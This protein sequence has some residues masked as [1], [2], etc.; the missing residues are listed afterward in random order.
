M[1]NNFFS[2][3]LALLNLP[4][5]YIVIIVVPFGATKIFFGISAAQ[6]V[7]TRERKYLAGQVHKYKT[8]VFIKSRIY[9]CEM[10]SL[11]LNTSGGR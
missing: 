5:K 11:A 9:L 4:N 3:N 8:P 7:R 6:G 10:Y 2:K 1:N